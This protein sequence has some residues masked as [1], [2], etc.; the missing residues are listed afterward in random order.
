MNNGIGNDLMNVIRI[1]VMMCIAWAIYGFTRETI[2][3]MFILIAAIGASA[4][5]GLKMYMYL[6][7]ERKEETEDN[8]HYKEDRKNGYQY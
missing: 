5:F 2:L 1:G 6:Y 3:S 4:F 7:G 8:E